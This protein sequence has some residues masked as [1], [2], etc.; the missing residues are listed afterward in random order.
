[1]PAQPEYLW[2]IR[3]KRAPLPCIPVPRS[4]GMSYIFPTVLLSYAAV[5][6]PHDHGKKRLHS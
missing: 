4:Y 2:S 5:D 3:V 6:F 1:M